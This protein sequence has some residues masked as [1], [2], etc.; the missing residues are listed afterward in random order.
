MPTQG[1]RKEKTRLDKFFRNYLNKKQNNQDK[2]KNA[3]PCAKAMAHKRRR[4]GR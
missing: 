2:K 1:N 4:E 3:R